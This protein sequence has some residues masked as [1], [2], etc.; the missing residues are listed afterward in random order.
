MN[1][2]LIQQLLA[3]WQ[4]RFE[5][6]DAFGQLVEAH[7]VESYERLMCIALNKLNDTLTVGDMITIEGPEGGMW[8]R[9]TYISTQKTGDVTVCRLGGIYAG[10]RVDLVIKGE[11][12]GE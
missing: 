3:D 2:K 11:E 10:K 9:G 12:G 1:K 6:A 8:V 7:D 5:I 4:T